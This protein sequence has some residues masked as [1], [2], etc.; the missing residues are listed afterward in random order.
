MN[1][2]LNQR[3]Q[4][5]VKIFLKTHQSKHASYVAMIIRVSK[6]TSKHII[7]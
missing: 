1:A 5:E 6:R 3:V 7:Q 4:I 2:D